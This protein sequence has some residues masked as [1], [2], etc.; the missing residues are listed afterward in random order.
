MARYQTVQVWF[1]THSSLALK[2]CAGVSHE[3]SSHFADN[4]NTRFPICSWRIC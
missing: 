4:G 2:L 3:A 1:M